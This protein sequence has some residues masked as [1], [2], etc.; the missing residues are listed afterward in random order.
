M[1]SA[2][3]LS[4]PE[5]ELAYLRAQVARKEAELRGQEKMP[6][7]VER[8]RIISEHLHA[9]QAAPQEI[10]APSYRMSEAAT[11]SSADQLLKELNLGKNEEAIQSLQNVMEE[12]G[13]KNA[14][15]VLEKLGDPQTSDDF[16]RHLVR[17]VA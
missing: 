17:Y 8:T 1:E 7:P 4:T 12:K 16:H 15:G 3:S 6:N 2:P 13:I 5:E 11:N 9:H 10:L 14:L